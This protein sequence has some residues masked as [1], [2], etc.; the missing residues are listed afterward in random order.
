MLVAVQ[1]H[2]LE[3]PESVRSKIAS[4]IWPSVIVKVGVVRSF[5]PDVEINAPLF[6]LLVEDSQNLRADITESELFLIQAQMLPNLVL[7]EC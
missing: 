2:V 5:E 1:N 4:L 6:C 3:S 7:A